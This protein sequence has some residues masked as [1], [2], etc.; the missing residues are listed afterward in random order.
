[1]AES[2]S[3][4]NAL[5]RFAPATIGYNEGIDNLVPIAITNTR[6]SAAT[7]TVAFNFLKLET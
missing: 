3:T 2:L 1:M 7:Y 6:A 4:G 5:I